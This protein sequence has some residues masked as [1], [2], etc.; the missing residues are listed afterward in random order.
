MLGS[1]SSSRIS[2]RKV[3]SYEAERRLLLSRKKNT[4]HGNDAQ[5]LRD[6]NKTKSLSVM[7]TVSTY[8]ADLYKPEDFYG[9]PL[10]L[11]KDFIV[12]KVRIKLCN[13][14][15][16]RVSRVSSLDI[17]QLILALD[18]PNVQP[19]N[20]PQN[21]EE[22]LA[23]M[24]I[25]S[26]AICIYRIFRRL[27]ND[28]KQTRQY[29]EEVAREIASL[30]NSRT[31]IAAVHNNCKSY[32]NY[33]QNVI[34]YCIKGNLQ[35]VLDE[36]VHMIGE[37]KSIDKIAGRMKESFIPANTQQV[38]TIQTFGTEMK[39]KM[40]KHF[41]MD[42]GSGKQTEED[43]KH[44]SNLRSAFNS[45][46][47]P[48]VL[49]S[50]SIGQEGLDFHWYCR[51]I[52]HWNLPS[53]PQDLEQREGRINRYK[54]LSVR[55]N[56]AK[57]YNT[58]FSWNEMFKN[59]SEELKG[60]NSEMVPFWFLPL[61]DKHFKEI[62]T[63]KIERIVPM[64]PLSEDIS[65]Y[66]RL[67][68]VLSLYRLTMGQPRQEELLQMLEDKVAPDQLKQLLFDLCP[69]SRIQKNSADKSSSSIDR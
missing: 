40:R 35:A 48:F 63:E 34:D 3:I 44:T 64:Y 36:F 46:F 65:K 24:A 41:A 47:R 13:F 18:D 28:D 14:R 29:A 37:N 1:I 5:L 33:F 50:T 7:F 57:L 39:Y 2:M 22:I 25:G 68:K 43:V 27:S 6:S 16:N 15:I 59:A 23:D 9:K 8:L 60:N 53:N 12:K 17:Y 62:A 51:K 4:Y 61:D 31:G 69:F 26:P 21:A 32:N 67:I 58:I 49:A 54:C 66:H 52:I 19:R 56:I 20:I 10:G 38:N 30:F 45:P 42:F 11:I 55:R